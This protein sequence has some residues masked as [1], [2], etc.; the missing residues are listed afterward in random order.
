[1]VKEDEEENADVLCPAFSPT[2]LREQ[3]LHETT[4][5]LLL[6]VSLLIH[7]YTILGAFLG[8][9]FRTL[10][11][12]FFNGGAACKTL[13]HSYISLHSI[14]NPFKKMSNLTRENEP[15]VTELESKLAVEALDAD[16]KLEM[17]MEMG[18][19]GDFQ[20]VLDQPTTSR[21]TNYVEELLSDH[22][23]GMIR[24]VGEDNF[25]RANLYDSLINDLDFTELLELLKEMFPENNTLLIRNYEAKKNLCPMGLEY[26]KIHV[27]PNDCVLYTKEF[28][29][30]KFCP[31][32]GL[33]W[34]KK[35][36]DRNTSDKGND[37]AP[38]KV[39]RYFPIIPR[40]KQ[41]FSI[42]E[43]VKNLKWHVGGRKRDNLLQ[44]PADS[45]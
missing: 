29:S 24:D 38:T 5:Q 43:D 36:T 16:R 12:A 6:C 8:D 17:K 22:L 40:L 13:A 33:S 34:F 28:V 39:M 20:K 45:P 37:D 3:Q 31:I 4:V 42:K 21:G 41:L 2:R 9:D 18:L 44:H 30:L 35:K 11:C 25:G 14:F 26:Q 15:V 7:F 1:M 10:L 23:E 27:C 32:C 19:G